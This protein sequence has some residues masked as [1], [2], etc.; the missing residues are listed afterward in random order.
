[1]KKKTNLLGLL[2]F[3]SIV[4]LNAQMSYYYKGKK[5]N[6]IVDRNYI[7]IIADEKFIKSS[8][9]R[10]LFQKF[11]MEQDDNEPIHGMI[12]LRFKSTTTMQ[13]Y[14]KITESLKENRQIKHVLPFFERG[15]APPIGTSDI[16]YLKLKEIKDTLLLRKTAEKQSVQI[17][18]QIPYMPQWYIL[19]IRNS[20]LSSSVDA[21]N[22]FYETGLFD[23]V[24]PAFMFN[25]RP[26]CTNDPRFDELWGLKNDLYPGIDI[27][28][29]NAWTMTRGAGMNVAVVDQGI[30]PNH[31]D[32]EANFHS[33]SFNTQSNYSYYSSLA[34]GTHVAGIV[35]AVKDNNL[36]V[37]GVAPESQIIRVS[38]DLGGSSGFVRPEISAEL[39]SGISWAWNTAGADIITNSWGDQGGNFYNDF[40]S[41]TLE[42]AIIN[43]MTQGRNGKGCVMVFATGNYGA[44]GP[45][46]DY[47][48][49]FHDD[50]L[51]VG[52]IDSNGIRSCFDAYKASGYGT[53]L[54]VVAPGSNILSTI[55]SNGAGYMGGTSMAAPHVAGIA[56]LI[57]S[58]NPFLYGYEV[59]NIIESTCQKINQHNSISNPSGYIYTDNIY[60]RPN[61]EWN[62]EVGYG[63]VNAY[64]AVQ[65]TCP[66]ILYI[67]NEP[68]I[69]SNTTATSCGDI[70][71]QY[72][73]VTNGATLT[74]NAAGDI[75]VQNVKVQNG[76]KLIL[77]AV[78]EVNIISDFEVELGSGFEIK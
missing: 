64:A 65:T 14:S 23:D 11:N 63:L 47:P 12:K 4:S 49:N 70:N 28:V 27:D 18:K 34:H 76:A 78:G 15:D 10:Q 58:I 8:N 57:L 50:I 44:F 69:T 6:L 41:S 59:R 40:Y 74:L 16:F 54:D 37:V 56:A 35:A 20:T 1:M 67:I 71:V 46:M 53:K 42:N 39:A 9:S 75:N 13:E 29:C 5:V 24:D 36:Q 68:P 45:V 26:N 7:H 62:D 30:D 77:D 19:S 25:F 55:P 51:T 61:G 43:A 2:F 3:L 33:L 66:T 72:V 31:N 17:V 32:L 60:G 48:A 52:S 22:Y 21:T 38:N 73:T